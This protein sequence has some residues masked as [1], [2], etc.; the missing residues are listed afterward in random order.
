MEE[1]NRMRLKTVNEVLHGPV[2]QVSV[3]SDLKKRGKE[4]YFLWTVKEHRVAKQILEAVHA[5]EQQNGVPY[6]M[7]FSDGDSL[8]FLFPYQ[9]ERPLKRFYKGQ[10]LQYRDVLKIGIRMIEQCM[11]CGLS[12]SLLYLVLEQEQIQLGRDGSIYFTYALDLK[13]FDLEKKEKDCVLRCALLLEELILQSKT[14]KKKNLEL[15]R[16]K[17]RREQYTSFIELYH[18]FK[19]MMPSLGSNFFN[20]EE[21]KNFYTVNHDRIFKLLLGLSSILLLVVIAVLISQLLFGEIPLLRLFSN[22]F[23]QI[24]TES[25]LQ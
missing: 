14:G 19:V 25:L 6:L 23:E 16:K 9:E 5:K 15:I 7:C 12:P 11:I 13:N 24:G 17:I 2:N 8:C 10:K 21:L 22:S 18:D 3:C 1:E 4:F 20:K